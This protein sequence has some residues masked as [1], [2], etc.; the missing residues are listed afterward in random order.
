KLE[1]PDCYRAAIDLWCDLHPEHSR[2]EAARRVVAIVQKELGSVRDI[3]RKL[4]E[5]P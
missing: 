4:F 1:A 2:A 5:K 3:A